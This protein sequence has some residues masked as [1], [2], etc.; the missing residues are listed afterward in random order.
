MKMDNIPGKNLMEYFDKMSVKVMEDK[1]KKRVS[2]V[3]NISYDN[4]RLKKKVF[5]I[6]I[7]VGTKIIILFLILLK[8]L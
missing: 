7:K 8:S 5:S 2:S 4:F 1:S 3:E 6:L